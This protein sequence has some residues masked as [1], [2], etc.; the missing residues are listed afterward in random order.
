[1][2]EIKHGSFN[3]TAAISSLVFSNTAGNH[4]SG[5]VKVYGITE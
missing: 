4:N 2:S 1:M 3:I 5:I